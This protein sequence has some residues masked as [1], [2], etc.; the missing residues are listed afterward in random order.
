ME[1]N[2][3][4]DSINKSIPMYVRLSC[5]NENNALSIIVNKTNSTYDQKAD[6]S[7]LSFQGDSIE[8]IRKNIENS[9]SL[10]SSSLINLG[11]NENRV[12]LTETTYDNN[13]YFCNPVRYISN[14]GEEKYYINSEEDVN[15]YYLNHYDE[16]KDALAFEKD[17]D[18]EENITNYT[19]KIGYFEKEKVLNLIRNINK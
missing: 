2:L 7:A 6:E 14:S 11:N 1:S 10:F 13:H 15:H 9:E 8:S 17:S 5:K 3:A 18:D 19:L 12:F 16:F 4:K